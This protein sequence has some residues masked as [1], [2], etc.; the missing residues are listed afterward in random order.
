MN[1]DERVKE[2]GRLTRQK[3]SLQARCA[4]LSAD[5]AAI[6]LKI[7]HIADQLSASATVPPK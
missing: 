3:A 1:M 7:K 4:T 2:L 5:I 6:D